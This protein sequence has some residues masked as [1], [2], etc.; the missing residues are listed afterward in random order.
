M[1]SKTTVAGRAQTLNL[2][3]GPCSAHQSKEALE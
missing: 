3:R 1:G 2:T